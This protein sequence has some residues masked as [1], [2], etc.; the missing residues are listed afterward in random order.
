MLGQHKRCPFSFGLYSP[1]G[2]VGH[3]IIRMCVRRV[4][5]FRSKGEAGAC[6]MVHIA[7]VCRSPAA[8]E[9]MFPEGE[10]A[11][12]DIS[13]PRIELAVRFRASHG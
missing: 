8:D 13:M 7:I 11:A 10:T 4:R 6:C 3:G 9:G 5:K 1:R 2:F 12:N